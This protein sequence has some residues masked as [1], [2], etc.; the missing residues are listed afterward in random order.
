MIHEKIFEYLS[1][2]KKYQISILDCVNPEILMHEHIKRDNNE[3]VFIESKFPFGRFRAKFLDI[4]IFGEKIIY[5]A[6]VFV[7]MI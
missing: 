7:V 5:R 3:I 1:E 4:T 6:N 2:N